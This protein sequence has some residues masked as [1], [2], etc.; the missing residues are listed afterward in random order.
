M[1][2]K[3]LGPV[4]QTPNHQYIVWAPEEP[5]SPE[6]LARVNRMTNTGPLND[7]SVCRETGEHYELVHSADTLEDAIAW[8]EKETTP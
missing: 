3:P 5:M 8:I 6:V 4:Y 2:R 1:E 7:F